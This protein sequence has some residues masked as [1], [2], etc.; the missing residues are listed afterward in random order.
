[1][2]CSLTTR[3]SPIPAFEPLEPRALRSVT[4]IG[5]PLR[6]D[7][8][9][10]GVQSIDLAANREGYAIAWQGG[11][12]AGQGV[13]VRQ[14]SDAG[15]AR[16]ETVSVR[17]GSGG[18]VLGPSLAMDETGDLVVAWVDHAQQ[19][20]P[21][22]V[23]AR[24]FDSDGAPEGD[25]APVFTTPTRPGGRPDVAINAGGAFVVAWADVRPGGVT[26]IDTRSFDA[27]GAPRGGVHVVDVIPKGQAPDEC[28]PCVGIDDAG[29]SLVAW[30][31]AA[32]GGVS[33]GGAAVV[34]A[35][36]FDAS[37]RPMG[38]VIAPSSRPV[39]HQDPSVVMTADGAFAI[40]WTDTR[41]GV[42]QVCAQ[43]YDA[44]GATRGGDLRASL[45]GENA[46][47]PSVSMDDNGQVLLAWNSR[48]AYRGDDEIHARVF[49]P[50]GRAATEPFRV[51]T[52]QLGYQ[53]P[54][55]AALGTAA[56]GMVAWAGYGSGGAGPGVY[57]QRFERFD[58][59]AVVSGI[60]WNDQDGDGVRGAGERPLRHVTVRL[61]NEYGAAAGTALTDGQGRYQFDLLPEAGYY[62][63]FEGS[64]GERVS[65]GCVD[66]GVDSET[67][68]TGVFSVDPSRPELTIGVGFTVIGSSALTGNV[69]GLTREV[70]QS[71]EPII[72]GVE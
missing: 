52:G 63:Q 61:F 17:A 8:P 41:G 34:Y 48:S 25:A 14:Y 36:R 68:R 26:R 32:A 60:A 30:S 40:A 45:A 3:R 7:G 69:S 2:N 55:A 65:P 28:V 37:G 39:A 71:L 53:S 42:G 64:P 23:T 13:Y 70:F 67:G 33:G 43:R 1:M 18:E 10:F 47:R 5:P 29:R 6:V 44:D 21:W 66:T 4:P 54:P 46:Q 50:A 20:G 51:D 49:D 15:E 16:G 59:P 22:T 24:R 19:G 9:D 58:H 27:A 12:D 57:A 11:A 62:L 56:R 38:G 72:P 35:R 31:R